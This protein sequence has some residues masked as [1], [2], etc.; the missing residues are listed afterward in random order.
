MRQYCG[1]SYATSS[2][3]L[4]AALPIALHSCAMHPFPAQAIAKA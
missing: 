2:Q 4:F 1:L 3:I